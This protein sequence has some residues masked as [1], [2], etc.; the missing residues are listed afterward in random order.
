MTKEE[1]KKFNEKKL[2]LNC[3]IRLKANK[4]ISEPGKD[5]ILGRDAITAWGLPNVI[6]MLNC[7]QMI[8]A[9]DDNLKAKVKVVTDK[10]KR[11]AE[12][13]GVSKYTQAKVNEAKKTDKDLDELK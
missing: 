6:R 4:K 7:D 9:D 11:L 2:V 10:D 12:K 5:T 1:L 13:L 3:R 8:L